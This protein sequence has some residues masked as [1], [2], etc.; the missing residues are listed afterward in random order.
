MASLLALTGLGFASAGGALGWIAA[1]RRDS[2][3]YVHTATH[4]VT[5]QGYAVTSEEIDLGHEPAFDFGDFL[6]V[7]LRA[8][9]PDP[10]DEVFVGIGPSRDVAAYLDG[11]SR[12]VVVDFGEDSLDPTYRTV[13]G[14]TAPA[15]PEDQTFWAVSSAGAGQQSVA[16]EPRS[17]DWTV[18]FM[19]ADA[20]RGV[21]LDA[22]AGVAVRHLKAI[23]FGLLGTGV[24]L[25]GAGVVLIVITTRRARA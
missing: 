19:N 14:E 23:V 18:V 1:N 15:R 20:H 16:W 7:R 5:S 25:M 6:S 24:V 17:G 10:S 22:D 2:A 21:T 9:A 13:A 11:A 12:D 4:P 3:G 8:T